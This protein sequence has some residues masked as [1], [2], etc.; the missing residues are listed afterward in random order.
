MLTTAGVILSHNPRPFVALA[1]LGM[2]AILAMATSGH[3]GGH[4]EGTS[5]SVRVREWLAVAKAIQTV[6]TRVDQV[7]DYKVITPEGVPDELSLVKLEMKDLT[8]IELFGDGSWEVNRPDESIAWSGPTGKLTVRFGKES[9]SVEA[10]EGAFST[11][12]AK[13]LL[14]GLDSRLL[15][16]A[17]WDALAPVQAGTGDTF[18]VLTQMY[19]ALGLFLP[20]EAR[21]R[22]RAATAGK[23]GTMLRFVHE[24]KE[25]W[26]HVGPSGLGCDEVRK[27]LS[28]LSG[29]V[30]HVRGGDWDL[31][32]PDRKGIGQPVSLN[33]E[34]INEKEGTLHLSLRRKDGTLAKCDFQLLRS[35][36]LADFGTL[37]IPLPDK[38]VE[39]LAGDGFILKGVTPEGMRWE[40][41]NA[42]GASLES[43][44]RDSISAL[45]AHLWSEDPP[46]KYHT[47]NEHCSHPRG[48]KIPRLVVFERRWSI[49]LGDGEDVSFTPN[50]EGGEGG[51]LLL[52]LKSSDGE[53][54]S[55]L[56]IVQLD[57]RAERQARV[58]W[59]GENLET[60]LFILELPARAVER[61]EK[62][63]CRLSGTTPDGIAWKIMVFGNSIKSV[64]VSHPTGKF[65]MLES[66]S[67]VGEPWKDVFTYITPDSKWVSRV[68][69]KDYGI[70]MYAVE[71][72]DGRREWSVN[73]GSEFRL[74]VL[75]GGDFWIWQT[76]KDGRFHRYTGRFSEPGSG[77]KWFPRPGGKGGKLI[78]NLA[79][80]VIDAIKKER[81]L[82]LLSDQIGDI[83]YEIASDDPDDGGG[84]DGDDLAASVNT[85]KNRQTHTKAEGATPPPPGVLAE[86][87]AADAI[88][89]EVGR[90]G[91]ETTPKERKEIRAN[92]ER[93][94]GH[95]VSRSAEEREFVTDV[96]DALLHHLTPDIVAI[97]FSR[98]IRAFYLS[99]SRAARSELARLRQ[100]F[101][102]RH[103]WVLDTEVL[104]ALL[105]GNQPD[106]PL[107][108]EATDSDRI[109]LRRAHRA[110]V[111][112]MALEAF[113]AIVGDMEFPRLGFGIIPTVLDA[114]KLALEQGGY[115][116]HDRWNLATLSRNPKSRAHTGG[117]PAVVD[118]KRLKRSPGADASGIVDL[119]RLHNPKFVNQ[120]I[121]LRL[122]RRLYSRDPLRF[123]RSSLIHRLAS[124]IDGF[125]IAA[126]KNFSDFLTRLRNMPGFRDGSQA[127]WKLQSAMQ[128]NQWLFRLQPWSDEQ[129]SPPNTVRWHGFVKEDLPDKK[130][131]LLDDG[132][133][134]ADAV[135]GPLLT[136]D[137]QQ[138]IDAPRTLNGR[139]ARIADETLQAYTLLQSD[140]NLRTATT[141]RLWAAMRDIY[142]RDMAI[143]DGEMLERALRWLERKGFPLRRETR[144]KRV[145]GHPPGN[146]Q[147]PV[148]L[149]RVW[150]VGGVARYFF[151]SLD[152]ADWPWKVQRRWKSLEGQSH[153]AA[154]AA[155]ID[156]LLE[157]Y[158]HLLNW[159]LL[160]ERAGRSIKA[161]Q[162]QM[163][164]WRSDKPTKWEPFIA[165][166]DEWAQLLG[167]ETTWFLWGR[168]LEI[169]R[170]QVLASLGSMTRRGERLCALRKLQ[171]MN[172][173]RL[174]HLARVGTESLED[175]ESIPTENL[176]DVGGWQRLAEVLEVDVFY[177]LAGY[178]RDEA[179]SR[180]NRQQRIDLCLLAAGLTQKELGRRLGGLKKTQI[181]KRLHALATH[182]GEDV[183]LKKEILSALGM[184][185]QELA[186]PPPGVLAESD[187]TVRRPTMTAH[188]TFEAWA[189]WPDWF[190]QIFVSFWWESFQP[191]YFLHPI[192]WINLEHP[193]VR[194]EDNGSVRWSR[195]IPRVLNVAGM[196]GA[197]IAAIVFFFWDPASVI[198]A[199]D[200][201]SRLVLKILISAVDAPLAFAAAH[202]A[203]N[204]LFF[205]AP[206]VTGKRVTGGVPAVAAGN[207]DRIDPELLKR[208][209]AATVEDMV[210]Q[211]GVPR[212]Y[213]EKLW[214]A[215]QEHRLSTWSSVRAAL[216]EEPGGD[217]VKFLA[218]IRLH[219]PSFIPTEPIRRRTQTNRLVYRITYPPN[220]NAAR[221]EPEKGKPAAPAPASPSDPA[222]ER[223]IS[224]P[225]KALSAATDQSHTAQA[226]DARSQQ[227]PGAKIASP[228][229]GR[230]SAGEK[231]GTRRGSASSTLKA[232]MAALGSAR[233]QTTLA[234]I[235]SKLNSVEGNQTPEQLVRLLGVGKTTLFNYG[236]RQL[237]RDKNALRLKEDSPLDLIIL[238][239]DV[240]AELQQ[241][242]RRWGNEPI[243]ISLAAKILGRS[244]P[245]LADYFSTVLAE[246]NGRR[247]VWGDKDRQLIPLTP[248]AEGG[249]RAASRAASRTSR[250]GAPPQAPKTKV[251]QAAESP[252]VGPSN[253]GTGNPDLA[254]SFGD[255]SDPRVPARGN[256]DAGVATVRPQM[257]YG[258][259]GRVLDWVL[260]QIRGQRTSFTQLLTLTGLA[261][262]TLT[263]IRWRK[264]IEAK[265]M[266]MDVR[267]RI[268]VKVRRVHEPLAVIEARLKT[269]QG[270]FT[271]DQLAKRI[272]AD[273]ETLIYHKIGTSIRAENAKRLKD[274]SQLE[275]IVLDDDIE[276]EIQQLLRRWG[277]EPASAS[278]VAGR[279]N[280][281]DIN[282]VT[283]Y[284]LRLLNEENG[285]RAVGSDFGRPPI[286]LAPHSMEDV[287]AASHSAP[288][289]PPGVAP[290]GV[291]EKSAA[292]AS[293]EVSEPSPAAPLPV[294]EEVAGPPSADASLADVH[295]SLED[296]RRRSAHGTHAPQAPAWFG[297]WV[298]EVESRMAAGQSFAKAATEAAESKEFFSED[299]PQS[300]R[301]R[302]WFFIDE[303]RQ[304]AQVCWR[305]EQ[306]GWVRWSV[307]P[308]RDFAQVE[309][310]G[311]EAWSDEE[312]EAFEKQF[313]A[314]ANESH[315]TELY[316]TAPALEWSVIWLEDIDSS[317]TGQKVAHR[318]LLNDLVPPRA[319]IKVIKETRVV[320]S[321][322]QRD[323]AI[324]LA[325]RPEQLAGILQLP[326]LLSQPF[327]EDV[328]DLRHVFEEARDYYDAMAKLAMGRTS[329]AIFAVRMAL[330]RLQNGL[331]EHIS[332]SR[333]SITLHW[334]LPEEILENLLKGSPV[335]LVLLLE[336]LISNAMKWSKVQFLAQEQKP[337]VAIS[338]MRQG[339]EI[340][341]SVRDTGPGGADLR[342]WSHP[343]L[344][345]SGLGGSGIGLS[346]NRYLA[347]AIRASIE[348]LSPKGE[349][350]TVIVRLPIA[351]AALKR[352]S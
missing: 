155:R 159:D 157:T 113:R 202:F 260:D 20:P 310:D 171:G 323:I 341:I 153:G 183:P 73:L 115:K 329:D 179:L 317:P 114:L 107:W 324:D 43:P 289:A 22:Q 13:A 192:D 28:T 326:A 21:P 201:I 162:Q 232:V 167:I 80:R 321:K 319:V 253:N 276:A 79:S 273:R 287:K 19:E 229:A 102:D 103:G 158:P 134:I 69:P 77:V 350:T 300:E 309:V 88:N 256:S 238:R 93:I 6:R 97:G 214:A 131:F 68:W 104:L 52:L 35:P 7:A 182:P 333:E 258:A 143:R 125:R 101:I 164:E 105:D 60:G 304:A 95:E 337:E 172:R 187:A 342:S 200:L 150:I 268:I 36:L 61:I 144:Q 8:V 127:I 81:P 189:G 108:R 29:T 186:A 206:M 241:L 225:G 46:D 328:L 2:A 278:L 343:Q 165:S 185:A 55:G 213:I 290:P 208:L 243:S 166:V 176:R 347:Q 284:F 32:L 307:H 17:F 184:T 112:G 320:S 132:V 197:F 156:M 259:A 38:V 84:G 222:L 11:G 226:Q 1:N 340:A 14:K 250:S 312:R 30:I 9:A 40:I 51:D 275:L 91:P 15:D 122:L 228:G 56:P 298:R 145:N 116:G 45:D 78:V 42:S 194:W 336:N 59:E 233:R 109:F 252:V 211:L 188:D 129:E 41:V 269:L 106:R 216:E 85:P 311:P 204:I 18:A 234:M 163:R 170:P 86:S 247:A 31:Q 94:L 215:A 246:E 137:D 100:E 335:H 44:M 296:R 265:N 351:S 305:D 118:G 181:S 338:A 345:F 203:G 64:G 198:P 83:E 191:R 297:P 136:G 235:N 138:D 178:P 160:S 146:G 205:W 74:E 66:M 111:F 313:L 261:R 72:N 71:E 330:D 291:L 248:R 271:L 280:R 299:E 47:P 54:R 294:S 231:R 293:L 308:G 67:Q 70:N 190:V 135:A 199:G 230:S 27:G 24:L 142:G 110:M 237:I 316:P 251:P 87:A 121:L 344:G 207:R 301:A 352:A 272:D 62:E 26:R 120:V 96:I 168:S 141:E 53:K 239:G 245:A 349:G 147:T 34:L 149:E 288:E 331:Q 302:R 117:V 263:R 315:G 39:E 318:L 76:G 89:G 133:S 292:D 314:K 262:A 92:I 346:I 279:L 5:Q 285:R 193:D 139:D 10:S 195:M 249:V 227:A 281:G 175:L 16:T 219:L 334:N 128:R 180:A 119:R 257:G 124:H 63:G 140:P 218:K 57:D 244:R 90:L 236:Y 221:R 4:E 212:A 161:L 295:R 148:S 242:L 348:V 210:S 169:M 23:E 217:I 151:F 325:S 99:L 48:K 173:V 154:V 240:Q 65:A 306:A 130:D 267:D 303:E 277:N 270:K 196:Y 209:E 282:T 123:Y 3:G 266:G 75:P 58:R 223:K 264:R 50:E 332:Y 25:P 254:A 286:P 152:A 224:L 33:Y 220:G 327:T 49:Y 98:G 274:D 322:M 177:L 174:A 82:I 339:Q 283:W 255:G 126:S 12:R 37:Y